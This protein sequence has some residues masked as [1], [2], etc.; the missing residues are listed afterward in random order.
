MSLTLPC[1]GGLWKPIAPPSR[2]SLGQ[3]YPCTDV[4][5]SLHI[6]G[7]TERSDPRATFS[8]PT[9]VGLMLGVGNVGKDLAAYTDSD[10]FL[11][12][13]AGFTW[14]E[15]HKDAH[16]WE[17]G[18]QGS[19]IVI[20]NDEGPTDRVS[21]TLNEGKTWSE[22][23]FGE[24]VRVKSIVTVPTDTSRKFLLLGYAPD[25]PE[26]T[27]AIHLDFS[28]ITNQKCR[29]D[30]TDPNNDDFELWSPSEERAEQCLFGRQTLYY[31]RIRDKDC[32]I[33]EALPQPHS[34]QR[35][36]LCTADDFEW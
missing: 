12:R 11:T 20:V 31:R 33:G 21:Y 3:R 5:C 27:V 7:Y 26:N 22:Y 25:K 16:L 6:H 34:V 29:L 35:N 32:Y 18:D 17:F 36:C 23:V 9:A 19:I 10:T 15:I 1:V 24:R 14:E 13:D 28:K 2:D 4:A 30:L 8:S